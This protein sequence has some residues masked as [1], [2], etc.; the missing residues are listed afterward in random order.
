MVVTLFFLFFF[1]FLISPQRKHGSSGAQGPD[2]PHRVPGGPLFQALHAEEDAPKVVIVFFLSV[3]LS[4]TKR[5]PT[6]RR[7]RFYMGV[8]E[9]YFS[10]VKHG[11]RV[12]VGFFFVLFSFLSVL[13]GCSLVATHAHHALA[14]CWRMACPQLAL[15]KEMPCC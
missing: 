12:L 1:S 10:P 3:P 13:F 8:Q 7:G 11:K 5:K 4:R 14:S 2:H 15:P 9:V 6:P